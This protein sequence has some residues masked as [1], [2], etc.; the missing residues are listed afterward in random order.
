M[1][2][3]SAQLSRSSSFDLLLH[4]R[5]GTA[6]ARLLELAEAIRRE[7]GWSEEDTLRDYYCSRRNSQVSALQ[8]TP[9]R[10]SQSICIIAL[11]TV[12]A[13][14]AGERSLFEPSTC[15]CSPND[16]IH[17]CGMVRGF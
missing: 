4:I 16:H 6:L 12:A 5:R 3:Y 9:Q 11:P 1:D 15:V 14:P 2:T 7:E 17:C 13:N 8:P 10:A